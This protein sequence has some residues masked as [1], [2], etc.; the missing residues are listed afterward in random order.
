MMEALNEV[1]ENWFLLCFKELW[2][3][4]KVSTNL[5]VGGDVATV[6]VL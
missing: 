3:F 4:A 2:M 6:G 5:G 1:L